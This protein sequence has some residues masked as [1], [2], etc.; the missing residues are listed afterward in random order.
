MESPNSG[1]KSKLVI[2]FY[3][4]RAVHKD[5]FLAHRRVNSAYYC[6]VL[7]RLSENVRRLLTELWRHKNW[8]L[9]HDNAPSHTSL[10]TGEFL[11]KDNKT[12]ITTDPFFSVLPIE[13][14]NERPPS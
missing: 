7:L 1:V 13:G 5:F 14:K 10:I 3:I 9:H 12:L 4:T 6:D 2:F 8:L 11:T